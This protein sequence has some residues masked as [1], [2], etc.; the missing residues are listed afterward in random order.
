M[1]RK[2]ILICTIIGYFHINAFTQSTEDMNYN[3]LSSFEEFVIIHKGT[4]QA[5]TGKYVNHKDDGTYVCKRCDFPLYLSDDKFDSHCGWPSFDDEIEGAVKRVTD[6]DGH[7]TEILCANCGGHLGHVFEGEGFTDKNT[8]HCVNSASIS[9]LE[10][11]EVKSNMEY[12]KAIYAGGCFWGTEYYFQKLEG[13]IS[14]TVGYTGGHIENPTYEQV[15]SHTSGHIEAT[16]VEYDPSLLSYE[17][18]TKYFFEIHDP[19]Q[20][21]RQGPDVGEQYRSEIFYANDEE[22]KTAEKLIKILEDKGYK[23][24]TRLSPATRFYDA[25]NYHQDFYEKKGGIPYCH[26]YRRIF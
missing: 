5:W 24:A 4:E 7:R 15:C 21:D 22:K 17:D 25:E 18:L 23:V 2:L 6:A 26:S 19:T 3:K 8:R 10:G 1:I 12:A 20:L 14:T 13:V 9:F 11:D 16:L